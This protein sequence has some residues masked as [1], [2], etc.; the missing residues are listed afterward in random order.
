MAKKIR[1]GEE[2]H[3]DVVIPGVVQTTNVTAGLYQET[4]PYSASAW[5]DRSVASTSSKLFFSPPDTGLAQA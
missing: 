2:Y 5:R 3:I 1:P 4:N